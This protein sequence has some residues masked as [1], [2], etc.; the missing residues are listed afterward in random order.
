MRSKQKKS[1]K[2]VL[3]PQDLEVLNQ[4][5]MCREAAFCGDDY[6]CSLYA[7]F[8][9]KNTV[10]PLDWDGS[11][12]RSV[13]IN[14]V[15]KLYKLGILK[16]AYEP[17]DSV[18]QYMYTLDYSKLQDFEQLN[19]IYTQITSGTWFKLSKRELDDLMDSPG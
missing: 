16:R 10:G 2:C 9:R 4:L 15:H 6:E 17:A 8:R 14:I 12:P 5:S 1:K 7:Y 18:F 13:P 3:T 19:E 11:F